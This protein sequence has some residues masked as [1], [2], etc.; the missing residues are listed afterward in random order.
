[1]TSLPLARVFHWFYIRARFRIALI[2]GKLQA[3]AAARVPRTAC[4]QA[5]CEW[6]SDHSSETSFAVL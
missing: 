5:K 6:W 3:L 4:S 2:G 1:M